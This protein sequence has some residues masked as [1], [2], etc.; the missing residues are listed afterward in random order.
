[1]Q[2][3]AGSSE[4]HGVVLPS[5]SLIVKTR[6]SASKGGG[7]SGR[8]S[9]LGSCRHLS[10]AW[11]NCQK[12][13]G[14][15]PNGSL[16][17]GSLRAGPSVGLRVGL[18]DVGTSVGDV[19]TFVGDDGS[20]VAKPRKAAGV[21]GVSVDTGTSVGD[22]GSCVA[23]PGAAARAAGRLS[24]ELASEPAQPESRPGGMS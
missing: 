10:H 14:A 24:S 6:M 18:R 20:R 15:T 23:E 13:F 22:D 8:L 17:K 19:G 3:G 12:L 21:E 1:M 9:P 11:P 4:L 7:R 2:Y 16:I 5:R